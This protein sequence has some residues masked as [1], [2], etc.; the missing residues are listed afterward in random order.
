MTVI[1]IAYLRRLRLI[2]GN[3]GSLSSSRTSPL[4]LICISSSNVV[5][6][7]CY[8]VEGVRG[9]AAARG[10]FIKGSSIRSILA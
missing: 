5:I 6:S 4:S 7:I 9:A 10:G 8:K 3:S 2:N 1:R